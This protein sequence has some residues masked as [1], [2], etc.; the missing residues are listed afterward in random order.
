MVKIHALVLGKNLKVHSGDVIS[1]LVTV[2][3]SKMLFLLVWRK[4]DGN[5]WS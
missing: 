1:L 2:S 3:I 5:P 4:E